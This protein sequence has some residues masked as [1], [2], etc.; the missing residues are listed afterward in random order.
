M[1]TELSTRQNKAIPLLVLGNTQKSVAETIGVTE[2]TL[3]NWMKDSVFRK[4]LKVSLV[5]YQER[6]L[7]HAFNIQEAS[8]SEMKK[9]MQSEESTNSEKMQAAKILL[10]Q[11]NKYTNGINFLAEIERLKDENKKLYMLGREEGL[12]GL[13]L[14]LKINSKEDRE[15]RLKKWDEDYGHLI[16]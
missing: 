9:I 6:A 11:G 8:I 3:G 5:D 14:G 1:S 12:S 2:R 15:A 13:G 4:E 16:D 10:S 7:L